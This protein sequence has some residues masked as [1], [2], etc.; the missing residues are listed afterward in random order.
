MPLQKSSLAILA[1]GVISSEAKVHPDLY[2]KHISLCVQGEIPDFI[3]NTLEIRRVLLNL[4]INAGQATGKGGEIEVTISAGGKSAHVAVR[5]H[6]CGI[7][8]DIREKIFRPHFTTKTDG[9]G[10]GLAA[11]RRIIEKNHGGS[12]DFENAS[13]GGTI[14][15]FS[16]PLQTATEGELRQ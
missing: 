13:Q 7:D 6:G 1:E 3:F 9:S 10:L 2:D 4:L 16:L 12:I 8:P 15:F 14:F 5:D 11:C